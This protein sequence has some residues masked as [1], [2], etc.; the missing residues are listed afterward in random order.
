MT[1]EPSNNRLCPPLQDTL[2]LTINYN[3]I[4][5]IPFM[6]QTTSL[7]RKQ[8][9]HCSHSHVLPG[10][11]VLQHAWSSIGQDE[12]HYFFYSSFRDTF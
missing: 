3:T 7:I 5:K 6:E 9:H 8:F 10:S 4:I 11:L 12:R 1:I 2:T